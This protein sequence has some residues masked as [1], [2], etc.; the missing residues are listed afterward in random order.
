MSLKGQIARVY[1]CDMLL[2]VGPWWIQ[3][4]KP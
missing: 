1:P 2:E 3:T 4:G